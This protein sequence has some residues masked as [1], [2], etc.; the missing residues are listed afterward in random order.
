LLNGEPSTCCDAFCKFRPDNSTCEDGLFC[1]GVEHCTS[2]VCGGAAANPCGG[3][4]TCAICDEA[5]NVCDTSQCPNLCGNGQLD[6]GEECDLGR[7]VNGEPTNCCDANCKKRPDNAPCTDEL[8]CNGNEHC[9]GGECGGSNGIPCIRT[10]E[11]CDE[12]NNSCDA[13]TCP[14]PPP[15]P[16][17][18]T[19]ELLIAEVFDGDGDAFNTS[20]GGSVRGTLDLDANADLRFTAADLARL[21]RCAADAVL[22]GGVCIDKYEAS[23]FENPPGSSD[24]GFHYGLDREAPDYPCRADGSDC[25]LEMFAYSV[26]DA[27]PSVNC[28]WFQAQQACASVGKR[29]LT[30]AEWQMAAAGTPDTGNE[31]DNVTSCNTNSEFVPLPAGSRSACVSKWGIFDMVG[32]AWEWVADWVPASTDCPGWG[33]FTDDTMCLAGASTTATNPGAL[34]RGGGAAFTTDAGPLAVR[35]DLS[36]SSLSPAIGFRCARAPF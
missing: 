28:T 5:N 10:C 36:P 2:G 13:S 33:A 30:N 32:N 3:L 11:S 9:T 7:A 23:V 27:V 31:D 34:I 15:L 18:P 29:L 17:Q 12:A 14:P 8:F 19:R 26:A 1:N 35:G 20:A 21:P 4:G 6:D 16:E 25:P 22:V 24:P